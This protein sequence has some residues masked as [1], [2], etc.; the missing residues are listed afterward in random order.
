MEIL[1]KLDICLGHKKS[2]A[3]IYVSDKYLRNINHAPNSQ[4]GVYS[5]YN[6]LKKILDF[7]ATPRDV[8]V[9]FLALC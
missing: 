4:L 2:F 7:L 8:Q 5:I 6:Y 9:I 3:F 1:V